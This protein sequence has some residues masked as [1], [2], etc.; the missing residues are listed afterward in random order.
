MDIEE[1]QGITIIKPDFDAI[2]DEEMIFQII[3]PKKT[4]KRKPIQY[5]LESEIFSVIE[6]IFD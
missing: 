1:Y 5:A 3:P 4:K 6:V 2:Y